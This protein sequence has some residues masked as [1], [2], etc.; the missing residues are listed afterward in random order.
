MASLETPDFNT[1]SFEKQRFHFVEG[2]VN[3]KDMANI[4]GKPKYASTTK[5]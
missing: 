5:G 2:T 3:A 4:F 1:P